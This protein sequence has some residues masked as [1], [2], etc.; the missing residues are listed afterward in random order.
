M[1]ENQKVE[2]S[3]ND[4]VVPAKFKALVDQV[5]AMSVLELHELVKLWRSRRRE[6]FLHCGFD[7][8]W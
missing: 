8:G 5:E 2:E 4:M 3:K 1:D 6:G 7:F